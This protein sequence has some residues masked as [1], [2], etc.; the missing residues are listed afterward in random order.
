MNAAFKTI[1]AIEEL[2]KIAAVGIGSLDNNAWQNDLTCEV[3]RLIE[4]LGAAR[5]YQERISQ[6]EPT[7]TNIDWRFVQQQ[8]CEP[9]RISLD[10]PVE[11][12]HA[13]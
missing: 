7:H 1:D 3:N 2:L 11:H 10:G 8:G 6:K 5:S 4:T 13:G 12:C 9:M